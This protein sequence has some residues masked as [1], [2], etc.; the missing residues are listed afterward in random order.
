MKYAS[1]VLFATLLVACNRKTTAVSPVDIRIP[2][3]ELV[4][5]LKDHLPESAVSRV[6]SEL[7]NDDQF[8]LE[9]TTEQFKHLQHGFTNK[10]EDY[11]RRTCSYDRFEK[12]AT[13]FKEGFSS[14]SLSL[15]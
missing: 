10:V 7:I 12:R 9:L 11:A 5:I 3:D 6:K 4:E 15:G 14:F 8:D 13:T 2:A 1:I